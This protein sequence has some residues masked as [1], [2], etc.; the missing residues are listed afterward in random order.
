MVKAY[1]SIEDDYYT[2]LQVSGH[3]QYKHAGEDL[4]C[5]GVSSI[6]FGLMNALDESKE[7]III[8]QQEDEIIIICKSKSQKIKDYFELTIYQLKTIEESYGKYLKVER[9]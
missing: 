4:V 8:N 3:A 6:M 9:K 5:A 7:D 1:Y 2:Y